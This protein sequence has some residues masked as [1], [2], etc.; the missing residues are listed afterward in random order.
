MKWESSILLL[1]VLLSMIPIPIS[2]QFKVLND[3]VSLINEDAFVQNETDFNN[4]LSFEK[5]YQKEG[6]NRK[7]L[8]PLLQALQLK[9]GFKNKKLRARLFYDLAKVSVRLNLYPLAMKCY[10]K[11]IQLKGPGILASD[12]SPVVTINPN[13][14]FIQAGFLMEPSAKDTTEENLVLEASDTSLTRDDQSPNIPESEPV[15]SR[16][17]WEAFD[18][19]KAAK[20]YALII[21]VKQPA[22]GRRRPFT[23][24]NNVG[25]TFIT[26]I[27]YNTDNSST[28][29]SF[30]FYP[31]KNSW[32]SATPLHPGSPAVF[33]DDAL[34]DWDEV[35]G[36]FVSCK[37]FQ[38][39]IR[40]I[41]HYDGRQYNLNQNNCTDFGLS[42]ATIAGLS[43]KVTGGIWP[44]GKGNNPANIGQSI[45]EGEFLNADPEYQGPL[46]V[47]SSNFLAQK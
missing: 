36:K 6:D 8:A 43:F 4:L 44:M 16:E 37:R 5:N 40:L 12:Q 46:F 38:K 22:P 11:A 9:S 7:A 35:I 1:A 3:P 27:K 34:H 13:H 29:R 47:C 45:L 15:P 33:K 2:A 41:K 24:I 23:G 14:T 20:A 28:S 21:Q 42:V 30:G 25:H 10:Y 18:D 19:G 26:L 39:I 31:M 32:L 17:I